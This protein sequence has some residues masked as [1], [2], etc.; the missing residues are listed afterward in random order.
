MC[1]WSPILALFGEGTTLDLVCRGYGREAILGL[2]GEDVGYHGNSVKRRLKGVDRT[3]YKVE[4]V[5]E[6]FSVDELARLV[7]R[8]GDGELSQADAF[9]ELGLAGANPIALRDL[10]SELGLANEFAE[11]DKRRR[12]GDMARGME[13]RFGTDNPF[14]L[15]EFQEKAK[16]TREERYGAAYTLAAGSTLAEGA[17]ATF[18]AHMEDEGFRRDLRERKA[19]TNVER[20]GEAWGQKRAE[21]VAATMLERYGVAHV[22][23]LPE[24]RER[25]RQR[26]AD[27]EVRRHIREKRLERGAFPSSKAEDV[28]YDRLVEVFGEGDVRRQYADARYPFPCDLY[29]PSRDLFIELN[30]TW[31]HAWHWFDATSAFDEKELGRW[32]GKAKRSDYYRCAID[33]WCDKD[34]RRRMSA[35]AANLNYV[36]FWDSVELLDVELWFALGCPDGHDWEREY[37][38]LPDV[39]VGYVEKWPEELSSARSIIQAVHS[40]Q[41]RQFYSRELDMVASDAV[42]R[43]GRLRGALFANRYRYLGKLPQELSAAECL[44]G[45]STAGFA[46]RYSSFDVSGMDKVISDYGLRSVYDPCAGWGERALECARRGVAYA[47]V[48]VNAALAVGHGRLLAR[49]GTGA[50]SIVCAD[51]AEVDMRA[52]GHDAVITCPPYGSKEIYSDLGAE[53]FGEEA[54]IEWWGRVVAMSVSSQTRIF[55]YQIDAERAEAMDAAVREAGFELAEV[56]VVNEGGNHFVRATKR[57]HRGETLRVFA[58]DGVV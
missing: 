31:L 51:A 30:G 53:N 49:Y 50:Q 32:Q 3:A 13:E 38:W 16:A 22:S 25:Q 55:A 36:V 4:H 42:T 23:Q 19:A 9:S 29:I 15:D 8:W 5:R 10:V 33:V 6:R 52:H 34:V 43:R 56:Y 48:D 40:A 12:R 58:R 24:S 2:T 46:R 27:P 35:E 47:G 14:K 1:D 41:W 21:R 45:I 26:M 44:R 11:A 18:A 57:R 17:R 39:P 7:S 37:S 54:F 20:Y 28:L